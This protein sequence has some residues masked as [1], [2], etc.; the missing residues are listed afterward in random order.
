MMNKLYHNCNRAYMSF[1]FICIIFIDK[2]ID[3]R[4]QGEVFFY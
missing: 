3:E 2:S 1:N 4:Q